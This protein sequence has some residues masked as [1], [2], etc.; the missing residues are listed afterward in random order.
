M[1]AVKQIVIIGAGHAGIC[2]GM[3]LK[4][5]R[6]EARSNGARPASHSICGLF[7]SKCPSATGPRV[8]LTG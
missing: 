2:M 1:A 3:Q 7:S 8:W 5:A 4:R 6:D